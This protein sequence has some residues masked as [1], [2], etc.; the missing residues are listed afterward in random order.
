MMEQIA[1]LIKNLSVWV[2]ISITVLLIII[3]EILVWFIIKPIKKKKIIKKLRGKDS[4]P[5][6][7][8]ASMDIGSRQYQQ[9]SYFTPDLTDVTQILNHGYLAILCD[10]MGGMACG[11]KASALCVKTFSEDYYS[12]KGTICYPD[13]FEKEVRKLDEIV[14]NIKNDEGEYANAG[15]TLICALVKENKLY[16][17]SIGDSR[18]YIIRGNKIAR[19]T[20]DHNYSLELSEK[21]RQGLI[22]KEEADN[23]PKKQALI[24]YIGIDGLNL[25]D[26]SEHG[27]ELERGDVIIMCS[28]G[29]YGSLSDNLIKATVIENEKNLD[30]AAH[31][32]VAEALDA[33]IKHQD[34]ISVVL[35]GYYSS[36]Q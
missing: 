8:S 5:I 12:T 31:M 17:A 11:D 35:I 10:G 9:D 29:L 14:V 33:D 28:D 25:I 27:L 20:Q 30:T 15:T 23:H 16:W 4:M 6:E 26:I 2:V 7:I 3:L 32:L 13:F 34:N 19:M 1:E 24:S 22:S 36:Q 21:V 18:I